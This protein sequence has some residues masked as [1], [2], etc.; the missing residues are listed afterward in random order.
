MCIPR[1]SRRCSASG[2]TG[3]AASRCWS[4][5]TSPRPSPCCR[6]PG[7][8]R[9]RR[10][11]H[12]DRRLALR[13]QLRRAARRAQRAAQGADARG[14]ARRRQLQHRR[15][16]RRPYRLFGPLLG[17]ALFAWPGGWLVALVDAASFLLAAA[18]IAGDPRRGGEARARGAAFRSSSPTGVRF[19]VHDRVLGNLLIGFGAVDAR[20]R[21]LRV[22]DLR[23]DRHLRQARDLRSVFVSVQGIG[24][25]AGGL[26]SVVSYVASARS[27]PVSSAWSPWRTATSI[28]ALAAAWVVVLFGA[29]VLGVAVPWTFVSLTTLMQRRSPRH[30]MGR[31]SSAVDVLLATPQAISL[32]VGA[33]LVSFSTTGS[34]SGSSR[35]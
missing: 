33:I 9:R 28:C 2:S 32:A 16:I 27:A 12:L 25:V 17:A 7:P 19:L 23:A 21:L 22:R 29:G 24:A 34:S 35:P 1:S 26:T 15:P 18:V 13:R 11:D 31:V 3:S 20:P 10:L 30:L 5:A 6:C 4:G 14:A 8:R